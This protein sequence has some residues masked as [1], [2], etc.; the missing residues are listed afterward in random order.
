M[1]GSRDFY[2]ILGVPRTASQDDGRGLPNPRGSAGDLY[3]EAR[4]MI[5]DQLSDAE[6]KLFEKLAAASG[7]D[8]RRRS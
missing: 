8:P 5:P 2:E 3:A 7:F 4:I 1:A 6:R